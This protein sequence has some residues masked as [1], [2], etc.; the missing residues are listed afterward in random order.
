MQK[1]VPQSAPQTFLGMDPGKVK[2]TGR[3]HAV[4]ELA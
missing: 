2:M 1:A 3:R 4:T